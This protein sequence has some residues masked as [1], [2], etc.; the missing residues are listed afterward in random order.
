MHTYTAE[1]DIRCDE[2]GDLIET[3]SEFAVV[4]SPSKQDK[5]NCLD[6]AKVRLKKEK[7]AHA[8]KVK[9]RKQRENANFNR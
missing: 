8:S 6:C 9:N 2:C 5:N 4:S 7:G 3:G 1:S